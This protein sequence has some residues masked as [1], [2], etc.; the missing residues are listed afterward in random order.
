MA[1]WIVHLRIAENLLKKIPAL[2]ES[3]FAV[4]NI[5]PDS[6]TPDA[7]WEN[8]KPPPPVTH[9]QD[10]GDVHRN[11][12][13]LD[14]YRRYMASS[15]LR[16]S[17]R[18]FSFLL[19]YFFHLITDN[20]WSIRVGRPTRERFDAEFNADSNFIWEVKRDW[21][22]LDFVYL[23]EHPE[24]LFWRVFLHANYEDARLDF[25]PDEAIRDRITYIQQYYQRSDDE[26]LA[27]CKRPFI[28]LS[29]DA[30]DEFVQEASD[31][32]FAIY[33][34]LWESHGEAV[35]HLSALSIGV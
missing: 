13:D 7:K 27:M 3:M 20:L 28:Y 11:C 23:R 34:Y 1:S 16:Q 26:T 9:F 6:G 21:Y 30:M 5:A 17:P 24:S 31:R 18:Q 10:S 35:G 33:Q 32:I 8:F 12:R 29:K 19:G 4:G 25:L 22:G 2:D 15:S 14:F